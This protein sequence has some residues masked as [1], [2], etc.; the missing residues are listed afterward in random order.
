MHIVLIF[1]FLNGFLSAN[2]ESQII[3]DGFIPNPAYNIPPSIDIPEGFS[4][5]TRCFDVYLPPNYNPEKSYPI[6]YHL[7]GFRAPYSLYTEDDQAVMDAMIQ[8]GEI[9]PLIIIFPD[10]II[11]HNQPSGS[12]AA[13]YGG[14]WYV[15]SKVLGLWED[16]FVNQLIPYVDKKYKQKS[17]SRGNK[18]SFRAIMGQSMGGYGSLFYGVKHPE[19]FSAFAGDSATAFWVIY[20]GL[21]SPNKN[22]LYTF[23]KLLVPELSCYLSNNTYSGD[24]LLSFNN[25]PFTN[26]VFSWSSAFSPNT[27]TAYP[28][29]VNLPVSGPYKTEPDYPEAGFL[30]DFTPNFS[31]EYQNSCTSTTP[32]DYNGQSLVSAPA[33]EQWRLFDPYDFLDSANKEL[34]KRQAIYLDSGNYETVNTV[35][36]RYFSDKLI[37]L[38]VAHEYVLYGTNYNNPVGYEC[39]DGKPIDLLG[40]THTFCTSAEDSPCQYKSFG[41]YRFTTN[42]KL[43]SGKFASDGYYVPDIKAS[44][45]GVGSIELYDRSLMLIKNIVGIETEEEINQKTAIN[46]SVYNKAHVIIGRDSQGALQIGNLFGKAQLAHTP[47]IE[48]NTI[49]F[50]LLIDGSDALFSIESQGFLGFAV[51]ILGNQTISPN[52]WALST[53]A[54]TNNISLTVKNGTF[55][56]NAIASSLDSKASLLAF[57]NAL[58][59]PRTKPNKTYYSFAINQKNGKIAG[60][61]NI[62]KVIDSNLIHPTVIDNQGILEPGGIRHTDIINAGDPTDLYPD[63]PIPYGKRIGSQ[64]FY[65]NLL[66]AQIF[67]SVNSS[68]DINTTL[69]LIASSV[70]TIFK[71]VSLD[72]YL[73]QKIKSSPLQLTK[74][75]TEIVTIL[76]TEGHTIK[77]Q[78]LAFLG[79]Q[80][81]AQ[82]SLGIKINPATGDVI[83]EY[84]LNP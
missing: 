53:L 51:G 8:N 33:V 42:L 64:T 83:A 25:G 54:N 57:G 11:E 37:D 63:N 74:N 7:G 13:G 4:E 79:L 78:P 68:E 46:L 43:F 69:P 77:R 10:G 23:N 31:M 67:F 81:N 35:G 26:Y 2:S 40:G 6:V 18:A 59:L 5:E 56:H 82:T 52:Y 73:K 32:P 66:N 49:D 24:R 36:A 29:N 17:D 70:D 47:K 16:Y 27:N 76:P 71:V 20:T 72:P 19:L 65:R 45:K 21:A 12:G 34:L 75:K 58:S 22:P 55:S 62:T 80:K 30:P 28:G 14:C 48:E 60:G 9:V 61:G 39:D 15:N 41:C 38:N 50:S 3:T 84:M 44:I 1:I